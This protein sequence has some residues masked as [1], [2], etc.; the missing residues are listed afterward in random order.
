MATAPS[1]ASRGQ[2]A[3]QSAGQ[4]LPQTEGNGLRAVIFS[5]ADCGFEAVSQPRISPAHG[6][7]A[8]HGAV[9]GTYCGR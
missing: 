6:H 9:L 4:T 5:H 1:L 3:S 8:V 7:A 2:A